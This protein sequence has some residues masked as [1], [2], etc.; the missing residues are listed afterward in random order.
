MKNIGLIGFGYM[1]KKY[2]HTSSKIKNILISKILKKRLTKLNVLNVEFF[3]NFNLISK[4][5]NIDG[6]I[7]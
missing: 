5:K 6:Y 3:R 4:D 1:G 7:I 2:F